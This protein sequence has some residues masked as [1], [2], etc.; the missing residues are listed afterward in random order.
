MAKIRIAQAF[1]LDGPLCVLPG[2]DRSSSD[3][4]GPSEVGNEEC[5]SLALPYTNEDTGDGR[6]CE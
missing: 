4:A 3:N 5:A 2:A 6:A 1:V